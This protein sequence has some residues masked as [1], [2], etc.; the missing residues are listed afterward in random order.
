MFI[1]GNVLHSYREV[2]L[3]AVY[4]LESQETSGVIQNESK[5][6]RIR[7]PIFEGRGRWMSQLK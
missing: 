3:P 6:L 1:I 5:G 2:P 7:G 4:K